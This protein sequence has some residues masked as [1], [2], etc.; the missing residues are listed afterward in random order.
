M[1]MGMLFRDIK[2]IS[3][4]IHVLIRG[5]KQALL[6]V[7]YVWWLIDLHVNVN[8]NVQYLHLIGGRITHKSRTFICR[9]MPHLI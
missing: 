2:A 8:V 5:L 4:T 7:P 1:R 6:V 3:F 9:S